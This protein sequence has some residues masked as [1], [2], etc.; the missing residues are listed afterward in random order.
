VAV[1]SPAAEL[2]PDERPGSRPGPAWAPGWLTRY[3][4]VRPILAFAGAHAVLMAFIWLLYPWAQLKPRTSF[5]GALE[6][7]DGGWYAAVVNLGY[8]HHLIY[9]SPGVP[10]QMRIAFPPGLPILMHLVGDVTGL[11]PAAAGLVISAIASL[12][13]VAGIYAVT[14][15][16]TTDAIALAAIVLWAIIPTAFILSMAYTE[17][18]YTALAAWTIYALLESRWL[19]AGIL[20]GAAGLVRASATMLIAVVC[21][22]CLI[23]AIRNRHRLR[24][25]LAILIAPAGMLGYLVFIGLRLHNMRAW[26]ISLTAPGWDVRFDWGRYTLSYFKWLLRLTDTQSVPIW[27][28]GPGLVIIIAL[29]LGVIVALNGRVPWELRA[30]TILSLLLIVGSSN[31][32]IAMPRFT[33]PLFA[34]LVPPAAVLAGAKRSSQVIAA[35]TLIAVSVW[36]GAI[37]LRM[38]G[39]AL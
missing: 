34:L 11:A 10:G 17:A 1:E 25:V 16:Y 13:A 22:A 7:G 31:M 5:V 6:G 23:G 4:Y 30:W 32:W 38:P 37:F 9:T 8:E 24:A 2:T 35:V 12:V 15:R 20:T 29:A 26:F 18:I 21:L 36:W 3:R 19:T 28:P 33:L 39:I 27:L 14:T